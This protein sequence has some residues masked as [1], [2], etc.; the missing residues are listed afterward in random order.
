M[1]TEC[2]HSSK[3]L[4]LSASAEEEKSYGF[5][6]HWVNYSFEN[7]FL[8]SS[9]CVFMFY[10][11]FKPEVLMRRADR[12][13]CYVCIYCTSY[14]TA[15]LICTTGTAF[16]T[17]CPI[18]LNMCFCDGAFLIRLVRVCICLKKKRR[19]CIIR[20]L[21]FRAYRMSHCVRMWISEYHLLKTDTELNLCVFYPHFAWGSSFGN[22]DNLWYRFSYWVVG[23]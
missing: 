16:C 13:H 21:L 3:C 4:P 8:L 14:Q 19:V 17:C 6:K 10:S 2:K 11:W 22:G 15:E 1:L 18:N 23:N 5:R 7:S 20:K 12:G 9:V